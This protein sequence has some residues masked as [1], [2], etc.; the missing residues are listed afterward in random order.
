MLAYIAPW[1]AGTKRDPLPPRNAPE[2]RTLN[3]ELIEEGFAAFFPIYPSL[4][5][6]A[7]LQRALRAAD[8]A[9]RERRGVWRTQGDD[10]LLGYE[11]RACVKLARAATPAAGIADA[12]QRGC[13]DLRT[14]ANTG[15]FAF[16]KIPPSHR[17]WYW[18]ADAR[19]ALLSLGAAL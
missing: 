2:R 4:P 9:W 8:R 13:I 18:N 14:M 10:V 5:T 6:P 7:D 12:F 19:E 15:P 16:G 11:L 17:L 1:F 3:L